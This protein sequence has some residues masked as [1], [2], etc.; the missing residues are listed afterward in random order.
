MTRPRAKHRVRGSARH[1]DAYGNP[2]R[3]TASA[4]LG[5]RRLVIVSVRYTLVMLKTRLFNVC[6][7]RQDNFS[8]R[9]PAL[10]PEKDC[11]ARLY[12]HLLAGDLVVRHQLYCLAQSTCSSIPERTR[13]EEARGPTLS[14]P[15]MRDSSPSDA[16]RSESPGRTYALS[17]G[18]HESRGFSTL[19]I[20]PSTP[21]APWTGPRPLWRRTSKASDTACMFNATMIWLATLV[22]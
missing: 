21:V 16:A 8:G 6:A 3:R 15:A 14:L 19:R 10:R 22:V 20:H 12:A 4:I 1:N 17:C 2:W 18:H 5:F 7:R 11:L 13:C 9:R